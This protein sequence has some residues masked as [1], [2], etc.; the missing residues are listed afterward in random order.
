MQ[1]KRKWMSVIVGAA[2]LLLSACGVQ[3]Q[4]STLKPAEIDLGRGAPLTVQDCSHNREGARL[5]QA[6]RR[7]IANDGFYAE[8]AGS[9]QLEL[10]NVYV[11]DMPSRGH[12]P[13]H[14]ER[15]KKSKKEHR[16]TPRL[17]GVVVVM[18]SGRQIYRRDYSQSVYTDSEGR[19][20]ITE[21]CEEFAEEIMEDLT[22]R[23]KTYYEYIEPDDTN[24]ALEQAAKAC[25]VGNWFI[26]KELVDNA[27]RQNPNCAEA[28]YLLGLI[29]RNDRDF[30][31]SDSY[32]YRA[33][34]LNPQSK[35]T[36]A[37][38]D[39]ARMQQDEARAGWQMGN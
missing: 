25:S 38:K 15:G 36:S 28:Y 18:H 9:S 23:K 31:T 8:Y 16:P 39:N 37:L 30:H 7:Q 21:A 24:P 4:M 27:L 10:H 2:A 26:G 3:I 1:M 20:D 35:Y 17:H 29:A 34:A 14:E 11:E 33:N 32:F 5:A 19:P 22:P 6:F 12:H 13:R